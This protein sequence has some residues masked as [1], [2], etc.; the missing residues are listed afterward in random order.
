MQFRRHTVRDDAEELTYRHVVAV[1]VVNDE[2]VRKLIWDGALSE[3]AE[4]SDISAVSFACIDDSLM[5]LSTR[6]VS[7]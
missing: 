5:W 1:M 2:E 3:L 4:A 7:A 6:R